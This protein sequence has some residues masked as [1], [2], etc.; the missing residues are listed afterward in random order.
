MPRFPHLFSSKSVP[1]SHEKL[2]SQIAWTQNV[3]SESSMA[4]KDW[5]GRCIKV[6]NLCV[7]K[8]AVSMGTIHPL[9]SPFMDSQLQD[10][11]CFF[12]RALASTDQWYMSLIG[13]GWRYG[14]R[15][16]KTRAE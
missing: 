14:K 3:F 4:Q 10:N 6:D 15:S 2:Y 5:K 12:V 11:E 1:A 8:G 9:W 13:I 7:H 16:K